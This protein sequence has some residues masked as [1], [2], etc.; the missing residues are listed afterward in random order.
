[1]IQFENIPESQRT[2]GNAKFSV[3]KCDMGLFDPSLAV[4]CVFFITQQPQK[5][6]FVAHIIALVTSHL[7]TIHIA[8]VSKSSL[9]LVLGGNATA[10]SVLKKKNNNSS[11]GKGKFE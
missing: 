1:M 8:E 4:L 7:H 2:P 6:P 3:R 9:C 11:N 5:F 10:K